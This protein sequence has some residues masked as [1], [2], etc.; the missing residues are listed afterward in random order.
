MSI[1]TGP[2]MSEVEEDRGSTVGP[3]FSSR[4]LGV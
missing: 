2:E 1:W 3:G 4:F